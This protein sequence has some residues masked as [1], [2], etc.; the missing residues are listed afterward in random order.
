MRQG[1]EG[2]GCANG[3]AAP[4]DR[5]RTRFE[6]SSFRKLFSGRCGAAASGPHLEAS[7]AGTCAH[8]HPAAP[9]AARP[10]SARPSASR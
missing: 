10:G 5:Q 3:S 6:G 9:R 1:K 7:A 8:R 2:T 4:E